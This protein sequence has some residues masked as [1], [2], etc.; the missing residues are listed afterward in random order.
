MSEQMQAV[1]Y[2]EHGEP[3]VLQ[4]EEVDR[5]I[6]KASELL[7]EVRTASVN[8][9]DAMFRSGEYG[10]VSLPGIPGGDAAGVVAD[11]GE[12]VKEFA[13]GDRV[14][15]SGMGHSDSGTFA[16]YA[17]IPA[18][19]AAHLPENVPFE[20]GGAIP[21]VGVTAWK[22][23]VDHASLWPGEWCLIHGGS[24][25][26][27]H[28]AVQLAAATGASVIATAGSEDAREQVR[29]FG[30]VTALDYDSD[31][32]AEEILAS[33][34]GEGVEV[35]LDH[36][37]DDYLALDLDVAAQ[38]GRI[39]SIMG[40]VPA[41]GGTPLIS[42]ELTLHGMSIGNSPNRQPILRHLA[43]LMA[44]GDLTAASA[45][46]YELEEAGEAHRMVLEGGYVGKVVVTP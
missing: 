4:V 36:R 22:A 42:K 45:R 3:D 18:T 11:V 38:N 10:S 12:E 15:A 6:P 43:R 7:V 9:V 14:F 46:T 5:P 16:E 17:A 25:G 33:T 1:R 31:S 28:V 2:H 24:G 29:D 19:K 34:D 13:V 35:I 26:V 41:V 32:L 21:N 30:A 37:L 23:L 44:G 27:G 20:V 40:D 8:P 39:V